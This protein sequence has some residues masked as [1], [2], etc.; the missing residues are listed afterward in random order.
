MCVWDMC[1]I[2]YVWDMCDIMYVF[3]KKHHRVETR[4]QKTSQSRKHV[5]KKSSQSRKHDL[6]KHHRV[7]NTSCVTCVF[8]SCSICMSFWVEIGKVFEKSG[9]TSGA[10]GGNERS[11]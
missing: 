2:M 5:L 9:G 10:S 8:Y 6:K 7:E 11:E 4:S 3:R 1:D